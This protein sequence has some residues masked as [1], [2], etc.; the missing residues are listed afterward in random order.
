MDQDGR[1]LACF[2]LFRP[3]RRLI[4]LNKGDEGLEQA[5]FNGVL[6]A[7]Y[8]YDVDAGR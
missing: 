7:A 8:H 3:E 6:S 5:V 2:E 4:Y 1:P